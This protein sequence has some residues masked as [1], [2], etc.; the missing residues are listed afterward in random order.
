MRM[1]KLLEGMEGVVCLIDDILIF[2]SMMSD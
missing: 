1:S 2:E